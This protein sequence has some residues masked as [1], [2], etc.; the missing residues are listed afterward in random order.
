MTSCL[1]LGAAGHTD[2]WHTTTASRH[3][4]AV[5]TRLFWEPTIAADLGTPNTGLSEWVWYEWHSPENLNVGSSDKSTRTRRHGC[6]ARARGHAH[7]AFI[8]C[9][10]HCDIRAH[11]FTQ[12]LPRKSRVLDWQGF[13]VVVR[14]A[15]TT[16]SRL[17]ESRPCSSGGSLHLQARSPVQRSDNVVNSFVASCCAPLHDFL[18]TSSQ[19]AAI[20]GA[21]AG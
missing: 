2:A 11:K 4:S 19:T 7:R 10:P 8:N 21:Q 3:L 20:T 14:L 5:L 9:A 15:K 18:E 1:A 17:Q 16:A 12:D 6:G 13:T